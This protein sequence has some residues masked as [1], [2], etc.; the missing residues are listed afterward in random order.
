MTTETI[1]TYGWQSPEQLKFINENPKVLS[2]LYD[3]S[4]LPEEIS[5]RVRG[6][7]EEAVKAERQ[8]C[9]DDVLSAW[10]ASSLPEEHEA[11]K[12]CQQTIHAKIRGRDPHK[13]QDQTQEG[14]RTE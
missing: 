5:T 13:G 4:I 11:W 12:R 7:V 8:R 2:L 6:I 3:L 10:S 9:V 14:K 1:K